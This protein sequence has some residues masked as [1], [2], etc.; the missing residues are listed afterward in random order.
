MGAIFGKNV[1]LVHYLTETENYQ[2]WLTERAI[3]PQK[4]FPSKMG[5]VI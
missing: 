4:P 5:F 2:D 3:Y 1:P